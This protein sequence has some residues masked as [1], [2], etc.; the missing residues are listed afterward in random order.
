MFGA[1]TGF[2][3]VG[4]SLVLV[5]VIVSETTELA[6]SVFDALLSPQETKRKATMGKAEAIL[7][8]SNDFIV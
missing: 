2:E 8:V 3:P 5:F 6:L 1:Q 7:Q 4:V